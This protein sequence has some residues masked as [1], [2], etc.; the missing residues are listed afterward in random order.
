MDGTITHRRDSYVSGPARLQRLPHELNLGYIGAHKF[1]AHVLTISNRTLFVLLLRQ[2]Q[3]Q[4]N[5]EQKQR[6][7]AA[8]RIERT[9]KAFPDGS[10]STIP[11][12]GTFGE[13]ETPPGHALSREA[14]RV[15][16]RI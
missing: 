15:I 7:S 11:A 13:Q 9:F 1:G 14:E 16:W 6:I 2:L 5:S 10:Y 12:N 8:S 3:P 4:T